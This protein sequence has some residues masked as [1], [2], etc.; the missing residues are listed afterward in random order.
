MERSHRFAVAFCCIS[1]QPHPIMVVR[2]QIDDS[3]PGHNNVEDAL[4]KVE[5]HGMDID[6]LEIVPASARGRKVTPL[7]GAEGKTLKE[8]C[9]YSTVPTRHLVYFVEGLEPA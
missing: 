2:G 6:L 1:R 8:I 4:G 9:D 3:A 5:K 7:N